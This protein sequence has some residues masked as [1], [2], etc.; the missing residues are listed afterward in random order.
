MK[1]AVISDI[2]GNIKALVAVLADIADRGVTQIYCLGDLVDFAPWGNEVIACIR[3]HG[4]P[5]VLGNHD[6]R[7]AFDQAI[8]PLAHQD[9]TETANRVLAIQHSMNTITAANKRW[10]A[11]LPFQ[12]ELTY[13]TKG[14]WRNILLV[15]ASLHSNSSYIYEADVQ[16]NPQA[17]IADRLADALVM[18]HTHLPYVQ[19]GAAVLF[20]NCGS[21]GRSK[22]A[23]KTASYAVLD[24]ND[25][26]VDAQLCRVDYDIAAVAE[27]IYQSDIP[28]FYGDF[29][30]NKA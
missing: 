30:L 21:V 22:E 3:E 11:E 15:H 23:K 8:T 4:I 28:D 9:A 6:E 20:V 5:C 14:G 16:Q 10:L 25:E 18:G 19:R 2:H 12:L 26:G 13:K 1:V 7:I 29:L 27:A 24:I 17:V